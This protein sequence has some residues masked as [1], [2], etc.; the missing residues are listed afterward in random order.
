MKTK[1]PLGCMPRDFWDEYNP[2]PD[3]FSIGYRILDLR[4]AIARAKMA[5][6]TVPEE[7][8]AEMDERSSEYREIFRWTYDPLGICPG[9]TFEPVVLGF[10]NLLRARVYE[11]LEA[12]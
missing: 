4:A 11:F 10:W 6:T 12:V 9:F 5:N 8:I 1:P 7:W 2:S 3:L